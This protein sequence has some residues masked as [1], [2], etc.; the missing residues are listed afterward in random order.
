MSNVRESVLGHVSNEIDALCAKHDAFP[1]LEIPGDGARDRNIRSVFEQVMQRYTFSNISS[2][3]MARRQYWA[4][5][6][7]WL[8]PTLLSLERKEGKSTGKTK[9]LNLF[10]GAAVGNFGNSQ[11][12]SCCL[13]NPLAMLAEFKD[14]DNLP[15]SQGQVTTSGGVIA[16]YSRKRSGRS[17]QSTPPRRQRGPSHGDNS[18]ISVGDA[19]SLIRRKLRVSSG[20]AQRATVD[21][22]GCVFADCGVTMDAD[23]NAAVNAGRK[24]LTGVSLAS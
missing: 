8:H 3:Q 9:P 5:A 7:L 21:L 1:V 16:L 17:N 19:K 24:W 12:C 2:H 11:V 22:Y 23:I 10:P 18:S 20:D 6:D 14:S 4:G 15:M 13:R